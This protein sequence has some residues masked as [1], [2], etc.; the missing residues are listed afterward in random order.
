MVIG[1]LED[2][3]ASLMQLIYERIYVGGEHDCFN[4]KEGWAVVHACKHPCH[5]DAVGY[6]GNLQN[7]HPNYLHLEKPNNLY[8][9]I[10]D[11]QQPLFMP[12]TFH[13]ALN[14]LDK[15]W[16]AENKIL[17]HCNQGLS[18]A[19]S[20]VLL[21]LAKRLKTISDESF[22]AVAERFLDLY[23]YFTPGL[24]IQIFLKQNWH[25]F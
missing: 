2:Q 23:P 25:S 24:G 11:P 10:I 22:E 6:K 16:K 14:F 1:A 15:H 7:T 18:R 13:I 21:F 3:L 12:E 5:Q 17:V 9:N 8:L 19:P 4:Q 20:L